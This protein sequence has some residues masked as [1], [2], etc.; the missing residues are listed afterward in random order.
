MKKVAI[1]TAVTFAAMVGQIMLGLPPAQLM[2]L[3]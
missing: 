2:M 3:G 1:L